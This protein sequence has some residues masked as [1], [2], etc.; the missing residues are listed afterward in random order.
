MSISE[1]SADT[2]DWFR[3][4]SDAEPSRLESL[5]ETSLEW[6]ERIPFSTEDND[7]SAYAT[8][9]IPFSTGPHMQLCQ[10][11]QGSCIT[12]ATSFL[13][14]I[15]VYSSSCVMGIKSDRQPQQQINCTVDDV[16]S[17]TQEASR[18]LRGLVQCRC[19]DSPQLQLL[20]T[21]ICSEAIFWYRRII[22]TYSSGHGNA[23][24]MDSARDSLREENEQ[25]PLQ[26][27]P[28]CIGKHQFEGH[29]E[30]MLVGQVVSNRLQELERII[31]DV[32]WKTSPWSQRITGV[33]EDGG[34]EML[35]ERVH[36]RS[37]GFLIDQLN[38][39]RSELASG[40]ID[41]NIS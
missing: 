27:R 30:A 18:V 24:N 21:V 11:P 20:V 35:P 39:A 16:L 4:L 2:I 15:H 1:G 10:N 38:A 17:T 19:H 40:I 31:G 6:L 7:K 26:R 25:A 34:T 13:K 36:T 14:S 12:M 23:T 5:D 8:A 28:F 32:A 33:G 41:A 29:T 9:P 37:N 3:E 22:A